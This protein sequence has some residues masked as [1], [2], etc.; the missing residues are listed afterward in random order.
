MKTVKNGEIW[1]EFGQKMREK[2]PG[3]ADKS[4][5]FTAEGAVFDPEAQTRRENAENPFRT[6]LAPAI[7]QIRTRA[8]T[9][10]Q[11]P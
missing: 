11:R 6:K 9:E 1:C 10:G 8:H 3:R 7:A 2:V 4:G 5:F